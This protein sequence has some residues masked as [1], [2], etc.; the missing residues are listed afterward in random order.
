MNDFLVSTY[1]QA[2]HLFDFAILN[3]L[4]CLLCGQHLFG[5]FHCTVVI[6]ASRNLCYYTSHLAKSPQPPAKLI[7]LYK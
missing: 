2:N 1:S 3:S 7:G 4:P 5:L 6:S